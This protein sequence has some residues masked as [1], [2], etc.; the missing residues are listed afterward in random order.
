MGQVCLPLSFRPISSPPSLA[1]EKANAIAGSRLEPLTSEQMANPHLFRYTPPTHGR[2]VGQLPE[3]VHPP[4]ERPGVANQ[5]DSDADSAIA[6]GSTSSSDES[7]TVSSS[8]EGADLVYD[9][10]SE[11]EDAFDKEDSD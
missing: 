4:W 2:P 1:R 8:S 5:D 6:M 3:G 10:E 11:V 7:A 9:S